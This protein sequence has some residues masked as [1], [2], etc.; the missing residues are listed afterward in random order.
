MAQAI[1][2][3]LDVAAVLARRDTFTHGRDDSSQVEWATKAGIDLVRGRGR[4]AAV[5]TVE[6]LAPDGSARTRC[7]PAT[8]S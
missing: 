4:L 8:P 6:V 3:P 2:G 7:T 5:K 1:S